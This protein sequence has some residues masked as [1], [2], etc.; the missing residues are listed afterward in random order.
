MPPPTAGRLD[1][2]LL[3]VLDEAANIAPLRDLAQ[4]ASTAAGLGIQLVT[5][6]QDRAQIAN[7]YGQSASTVVN[8]HRAKLVLS[9]VAD[10]GT[11][12]DVAQLVGET[13]VDR[14]S[15]TVDDQGRISATE[16]T[17]SRLLATSSGI[18]TLRPFRGLL[19]YG[20]VRPALVDLRPFWRGQRR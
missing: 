8:N 11:T 14:R 7:R 17:Q 3:L 4:I 10:T 16:A 15:T 12:S 2:P 6:W 1:P 20:H 9:G 18:R 13:E 5:V 19:V